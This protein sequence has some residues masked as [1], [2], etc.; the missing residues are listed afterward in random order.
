[1][2][3]HG[4]T[5]TKELQGHLLR[6]A[7][8]KL[9]SLGK[10]MVG[11]EE[12]QHGDKVSKDT[13]IYSW[14]DEKAAL[15][16]AKQGYDVVLQPAQTTYLDIVQDFAPD[17]PGVDW[18]GVLPLEVAYRYE[19]LNDLTEDDPIRKRVLGIQCALWC[20]IINHQARIDYMLFPRLY[21]VAEAAWTEKPNKDWIDFLS[22]LKGQLP[23]LD[24][25]GVNYRNPWK[26]KES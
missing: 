25:Q 9:K 26:S 13:V 19:T 2:A 24:R 4:Y 23:H 14:R 8:K 1:M 5:D 12:A 6:Y 7:E 18:S 15:F 16:C 11:W 3:E 22:R 20:E 21:A 10:R 17:E